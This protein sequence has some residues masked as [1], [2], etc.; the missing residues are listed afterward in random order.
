MLRFPNALSLPRVLSQDAPSR[1]YTLVER[2]AHQHMVEQVSPVRTS[3]AGHEHR[4][5]SVQRGP[6]CLCSNCTTHFN[7]C[8]LANMNEPANLEPAVLR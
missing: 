8:A 6:G 5:I 4:I 2:R 3:S 7:R 1:R